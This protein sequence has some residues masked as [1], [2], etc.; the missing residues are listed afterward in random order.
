M[1]AKY[2]FVLPDDLVRREKLESPLV[3]WK[4]IVELGKHQK[5]HQHKMQPGINDKTF[6]LGP[7]SK[8]HVG[9]AVNALSRATGA[10]LELM[11][12]QL[13]YPAE[14]KTTAFFCNMM[15]RWFDLMSSRNPGHCFSLGEK[16]NYLENIQFLMDF[17]EM[18]D[19]LHLVK[20]HGD[21]EQLIQQNVRLTTTSMIMT[22]EYYLH[23]RGFKFLLGG[24]FG[25]DCVE[26]FISQVRRRMTTPTALNFKYA[27]RALL[28]VNHMKPSKSSS[29][30][31][32]ENSSNWLTELEHIRNLKMSFDD[33]DEDRNV[34]EVL[35]GDRVTKDFSEENALRYLIGYLFK[36]TIC[37][38]SKCQVC[39]DAFVKEHCDAT[40]SEILVFK[41]C[42]TP[43]ALVMVTEYAYKIFSMVESSFLLNLASIDNE[44]FFDAL[45]DKLVITTK[46]MFE[47]DLPTCHWTLLIKRFL[48][49]RVY[50]WVR[51][52]TMD[53]KESPEFQAAKKEAGHASKKIAGHQLA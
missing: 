25:S 29:Y 16:G 50:F 21:N 36:K 47:A 53:A 9:P 7:F 27:F 24:R 18:F 51:K 17:M 46:N 3:Q 26:N 6:D 23:E 41:R 33:E 32:D 19:S 8:M 12:D 30:F 43:D 4:H 10:V 40:E 48:K 37:S 34:F 11:V 52:L 28:I 49:I 2:P 1:L 42:Y 45:V 15:G 22:A 5:K 38:E 20:E 39:L 35:I 13:E 14:F 44:R 31:E